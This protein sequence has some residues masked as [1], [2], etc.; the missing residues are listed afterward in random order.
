MDRQMTSGMPERRREDHPCSWPGAV[1]RTASDRLQAIQR[2]GTVATSPVEPVWRERE[3]VVATNRQEGTFDRQ[4]CQRTTR[5]EMA[6]PTARDSWTDLRTLTGG[7]NPL[8]DAGPV[9]SGPDPVAHPLDEL[10][11]A[12][13]CSLSPLWDSAPCRHLASDA[14]ALFFSNDIAEIDQ[15]K[16]ICSSCPVAAPCLK[17]ALDRKEP[18]GVWGGH[19]LENGRI[20]VNKRPRGRPRKVQQ[21][22]ANQGQGTSNHARSA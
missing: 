19:L 7:E 13:R 20:L 2:L 16:R 18:C 11:L 4:I 1:F 12:L 15:A 5:T 3:A 8:T 9:R 17:G 14:T 22:A 6:K 21:L 10:A